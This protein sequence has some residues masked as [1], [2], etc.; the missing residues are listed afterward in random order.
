MIQLKYL[1]R[2]RVKYFK[3]INYNFIIKEA[4]GSSV[5]VIIVGNKSDLRD[6]GIKKFKVVQTKDGEKI[7]QVNQ[8]IKF[9]YN[10]I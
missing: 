9:N 2:F 6:D 5:P 3:L 4:A 1:I 8:T 7:A 10:F